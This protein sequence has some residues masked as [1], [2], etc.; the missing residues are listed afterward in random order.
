MKRFANR[1]NCVRA[2]RKELEDPMAKAGVHFTVTEEN[3]SFSYALT[4]RKPALDPLELPAALKRPAPSAEEAAAIEARLEKNRKDASPE[5]ELVVPKTTASSATK[6]P[7]ETKIGAVLAKAMSE[8]GIT[9]DEVHEMTGWKKI[10]G[11][12]GAAKRS[13][14]TLTRTREGKVTTYRAHAA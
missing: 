4:P 1:S 9:V 8:T 2:A 3:G 13:G 11:F 7:R 14:L 10:G 6:A 5:R 12:F